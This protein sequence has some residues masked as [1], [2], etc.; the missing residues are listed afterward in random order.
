MKLNAHMFHDLGSRMIHFYCRAKLE[1]MGFNG[2]LTGSCKVKLSVALI[3]L[4]HWADF[5][6]F[7]LDF[8]NRVKSTRYHLKNES[9]CFEK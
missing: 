7:I 6:L 3:P 2:I 8:F 5:Y 4:K 1:A 9:K